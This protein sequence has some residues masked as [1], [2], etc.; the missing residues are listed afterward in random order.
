MIVLV[1]FIRFCSVAANLVQFQAD[2]YIESLVQKC[3][4]IIF[5][6]TSFMFPAV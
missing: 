1:I 4:D 6:A 3:A 5:V 2:K